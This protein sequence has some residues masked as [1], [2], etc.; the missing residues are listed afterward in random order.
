MCV[1]VCASGVEAPI[2]MQLRFGF[3]L[4]AFFPSFF[5]IFFGFFSCQWQFIN[6]LTFCHVN[7]KKGA[8]QGA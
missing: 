7:T 1:C 2:I 4:V 5:A 3:Q 6:C 8:V